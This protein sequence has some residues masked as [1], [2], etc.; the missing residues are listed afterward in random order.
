MCGHT[1]IRTCA[2]AR[3]CVRAQVQNMSDKADITSSDDLTDGDW[4]S[5]AI[6][7]TMAELTASSSLI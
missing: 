3:E 7:V 2:H 1:T 5:L 6:I 4:I